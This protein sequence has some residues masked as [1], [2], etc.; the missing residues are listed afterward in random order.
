M[1]SV[2][3]IR[4]LIRIGTSSALHEKLNFMNDADPKA[5]TSTTS[6]ALVFVSHDTRDAEIAEAF[7]RLLSSV[8]AGVLKSFRSSDKKGN[9]GI[10]YGVDW[11]PEIMG[12]LKV[13][14]DVV[15][16]LT[17]FSINRP[18]ILYEAGVAKG[19]LDTPVHGLAVGIPLGKA[20]TGPFA[21]FQNCDDTVESI[22]SLVI[23]L[24]SRIPN[25]EPDRDVVIAQ[26][27][28]FRQRC[29]ESLK[30][31][32]HEESPVSELDSS[33]VAKLFEEIKVMY[34]DLPGRI[35]SRI[36][37]GA[38]PIRNRLRIHPKMLL[39]MSFSERG[40]PT[41]FLPLVQAASVYREELPWLY[42][43]SYELFIAD[44]SG[45]HRQVQKLLRALSAALQAQRRNPIFDDLL[46]S[47]DINAFL[48]E[49]PEL[50]DYIA[51]ASN[52]RNASL[53]RLEKEEL[54]GGSEPRKTR[55]P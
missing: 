46:M 10:E 5:P 3:S 42:D 35:E 20:S 48:R 41:A 40:G 26:V 39:E 55:I 18:W 37:D 8:S 45:D 52:D 11:Y 49:L 14:S 21:Q 53:N 38:R 19:H 47:K 15:C 24:V 6:K 4:K 2:D 13:A 17:P 7:S 9:Q 44:E 29:E 34:Q 32:G 27:S 54:N 30:K 33:S 16:L 22:T 51:I 1:I 25:A 36:G 12:K 43:L 23:Q 31:Q 50:L 28:S